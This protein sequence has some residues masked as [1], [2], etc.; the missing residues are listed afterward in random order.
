MP[1]IT[2]MLPRV[3]GVVDAEAT[4][5]QDDEPDGDVQHAQTHHGEA[6]DRAGGEGH[7][8]ALV[9]ALAGGLSGAGVGAGGDL[10]AHEAGQHGPDTAGEKGEGGELGEHLSPG[11]QRP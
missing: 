3:S 6:H 5:A 1:F 4:I 2:M 9:Q 11:G 7:P 8:Q 10:H